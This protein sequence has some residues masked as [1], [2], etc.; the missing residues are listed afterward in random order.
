MRRNNIETNQRG[1]TESKWLPVANFSFS[2]GSVV[3][4]FRVNKFIW[5]P[6]VNDEHSV[7]QERS[8]QQE[9]VTRRTNVLLLLS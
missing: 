5:T 3:R 9:V 2:F 8:V 4:G 7:Q 6:V 1:N